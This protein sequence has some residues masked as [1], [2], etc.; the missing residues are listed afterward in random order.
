[1]TFSNGGKKFS[2]SVRSE[3]GR[4][5]HV[6]AAFRLAVAGQ[7]LQGG[8]YLAGREHAGLALALQAFHRRNSHLADQVGVLAESFLDAAPARIARDI[9]HGGERLTHA[10]GADLARRHDVDRA[11]QRG[12]PAGGQGD[13]LRKAG[14]ADRRI[15]VQ[16]FLVKQNGN[17]EPRA[18]HGVV[19]Q[20]VHEANRPGNIPPAH[21]PGRGGAGGIRRPRKRAD[22]V[23]ILDR[24]F[25]RIELQP[26][27]EH[28]GLV[29]P[30]AEHLRDFL[31]QRHARQQVFDARFNRLFGV[32]VGSGA[33]RSRMRLG[34]EREAGRDAAYPT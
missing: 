28:V 13:G 25:G 22:A 8:E 19:L 12:V 18:G 4:G 32:L 26:G 21:H 16:S 29:L 20:G 27:V 17:A 24:H 5:A 6:G 14:G 23:G 10:A 31:L 34:Q 9:D 2:R 33:W 1:M 30:D 11:H 15:A 7:M 3:Y